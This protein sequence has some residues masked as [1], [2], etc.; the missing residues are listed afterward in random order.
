MYG[1]RYSI[2][3][4]VHSCVCIAFWSYCTVY[5]TDIPQP[6]THVIHKTDVVLYVVHTFYPSPNNMCPLLLYK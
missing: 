5:V 2:V 1:T 3:D 6:D 4:Q